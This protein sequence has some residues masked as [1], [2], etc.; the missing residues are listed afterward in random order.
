MTDANMLSENLCR[1]SEAR[2]T[3]EKR[4]EEVAAELYQ[5]SAALQYR[6]QIVA[7]KSAKLRQ[8]NEDMEQLRLRLAH[9]EKMAK[10][11]LLLA[12][13]GEEIIHPLAF[14]AENLKSVN[15]YYHDIFGLIE[16]QA[17]AVELSQ[18]T[19]VSQA[20]QV[21][22]IKKLKKKINFDFIKSDI[23]SLLKDSDEAVVR[24]QTLVG[25]VTQ[26]CAAD[27]REIAEEDINRLLDR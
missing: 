1:E 27:R 4:L 10:L 22:N 12:G 13:I 17:E 5:T 7:E 9:S 26:F 23:G 14:I 21:K 20:A 25:D 24:V 16:Q 18:S 3:A 15:S 11:G 8:V 2:K 6:T 19:G